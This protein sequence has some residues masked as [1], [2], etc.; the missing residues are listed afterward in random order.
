MGQIRG[1]VDLAN[2]TL[3]GR[4][5]CDT[6]VE[7]LDGD[8]AIMPDVAGK[9][10]GGESAAPKFLLDLVATGKS[11]AQ[12]SHGKRHRLNL[13]AGGRRSPYRAVLEALVSILPLDGLVETNQVPLA[14]LV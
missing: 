9:E 1:D 12:L 5:L 7:N 11:G 8:L 3:R 2:E 4:T 6:G 14:H 10:N 13:T